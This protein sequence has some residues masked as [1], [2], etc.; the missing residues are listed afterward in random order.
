MN[1][2]LMI[3]NLL[4]NQKVFEEL[5]M[6]IP[7][8]EYLWKDKPNRWCLLEIV[9]HLYD[10]ERE[11]FRKRTRHILETPNKRFAPIDPEGWVIDRR[12]IKQ[13]YDSML[14]DFLK[15]RKA[16]I[17][18][19]NSLINPNWNNVTI[20]KDFGEMSA[21]QFLANWLA[22]DYLH[23]RQVTRLKLDYV[24]HMSRENFSYAEGY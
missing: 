4:R 24:K 12:Y 6:G 16:S 15:E 11:D 2:Q 7:S 23:F 22:H 19:L 9:C 20:H 10:E 17:N 8:E 3:N 18:W 5:F 1:H 21:Q 13:E 14:N